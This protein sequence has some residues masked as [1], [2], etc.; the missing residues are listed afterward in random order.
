MPLNNITSLELENLSN[1]QVMKLMKSINPS[2]NTHITGKNLNKILYSLKYITNIMPLD[3]ANVNMLKELYGRYDTENT[4]FDVCKYGDN[5]KLLN[6]VKD[7]RNLLNSVDKDGNTPLHIAVYNGKTKCVKTL[8]R[9]KAKY[10]ILNNYKETPLI[11]AQKRMQKYSSINRTKLVLTYVNII[12][13]LD[14]PPCRMKDH[15]KRGNECAFFHTEEEKRVFKIINK[16]VR[17]CYRIKRCERVHC[18]TRKLAEQGKEYPPNKCPYAHNKK[19]EWCTKCLCYGHFKE[20]C[21]NRRFVEYRKV[22]K[23]IRNNNRLVK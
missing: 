22:E 8:M 13:A 18:P 7:N 6:I 11:I 1:K 14:V 4:I 5:D 16:R 9:Y 20:N 12:E 19:E 17:H 15:C 2:F 23:V 3:D 21:G 10:N